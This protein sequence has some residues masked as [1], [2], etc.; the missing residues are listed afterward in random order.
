MAAE[1]AAVVAVVA[2]QQ[3]RQLQG[4]R[5]WTTATAWSAPPFVV[6]RANS[7][8][9]SELSK[10][11][12]QSLRLLWIEIKGI[13]V[14]AEV[15]F[16]SYVSGAGSWGLWRPDFLSPWRTPRPDLRTTPQRALACAA[17][18]ARA[19]RPPRSAN[20]PRRCP[21][22]RIAT[23]RHGRF[24]PVV[25]SSAILVL[26]SPRGADHERWWPRYGCHGG[27]I[28]RKN[29]PARRPSRTWKRSGGLRVWPSRIG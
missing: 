26:S 27:R 12:F 17:S 7:V 9:T 25:C 28:A 20:L 16:L 4:G 19:P 29:E 13:D 5:M 11:C 15:F 23:R 18:L 10:I 22:L 1:K 2:A 6:R 21:V 24:Q 3:Q 8:E 14:C